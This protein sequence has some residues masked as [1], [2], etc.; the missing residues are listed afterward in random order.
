[1]DSS[2][3]SPN[4]SNQS[5]PF[6]SPSSSSSYLSDDLSDDFNH[7]SSDQ[8][9]SIKILTKSNLLQ[10]QEKQI[11]T[12]QNITKLPKQTIKI[13]LINYKWNNDLLLEDYLV[14]AGLLVGLINN[15]TLIN[16]N[17]NNEITYCEICCDDITSYVGVCH[18]YCVSCYK[19]YLTNKITEGQENIQ[20]IISYVLL[21]II[22]NTNYNTINIKLLIIIK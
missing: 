15:N 21:I 12:L 3:S 10:K 4:Q 7:N 8:S 22:I 18:F 14:N 1:M 6:N 13:L 2:P 16:N 20:V 9:D 11:T 19:S 17:N 5:S